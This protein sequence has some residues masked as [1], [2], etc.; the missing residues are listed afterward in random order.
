MH[1]RLYNFLN[2][3]NSLK[4]QFGFRNTYSTTHALI[5]I[6]ETIR[7][8]IDNDNF[9]CGVFVDLQKAFDTVDHDILLDKLSHYGIRGITNQWFKTF[10]KNRTINNVNSSTCDITHGVPQGSV[11]GPLLFLIYIND[12][13][14]AIEHSVM[15][16]FADDTNL[17]YINKSLKKINKYIN[18]DLK[19]LTQWLRANK[20][21]LNASKTEIVIFRSKNKSIN[22][23]L[24]FRI[25]GQKIY[26]TNTIK[27]LGLYIDEFLSWNEHLHCLHLKLSRANGMIAKIRHYL[28]QET[29]TCI[30]YAIF[31]SHLIYGCQ[32]WGQTK[33][34][35]QKLFT[36][37][38]TALRLM[39]FKKQGFNTNPLFYENKI[40]KLHDYVTF[41]NSLFVYDFYKDLL[42]TTFK[43]LF[44]PVSE[45]H[46]HKTRAAMNNQL[47]ISQF[48]TT[49]YGINSINNQSVLAWN[50]LLRNMDIDLRNTTRPQFYKKVKK[51]T[52]DSY[53]M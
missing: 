50:H 51:I 24:N 23:K 12:L 43:N 53:N 16:H 11:L 6:T 7:Q 29:L 52:L 18:H 34:T 41:L 2:K 21:S 27:Y 38:E 1:G 49:I 40:L 36:L 4:H 31:N 17:T 8:A 13:H 35:T 3:S 9:A 47:T 10:L 44:Q 46:I 28:S 33:R 45:T 20:I 15:H 14:T 22:K 26:P 32:I 39:N 48:R 37:Q 42:P 30:Y 25:N 5:Q 19:L